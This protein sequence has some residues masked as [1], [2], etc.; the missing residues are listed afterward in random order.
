MPEYEQG[1]SYIYSVSE[2]KKGNMLIGVGGVYKKEKAKI[3]SID[4]NIDINNLWSSFDLPPI[5]TTDSTDPNIYGAASIAFDDENKL[6]VGTNVEGVLYFNNYLSYQIK[7]E[8]T[9]TFTLFPNPAS[10][11]V[12]ITISNSGL[13]NGSISI[14]NSS[15]VE[16]KRFDEKELSEQSSMCFSIEGFSTGMYYCA[17]K[18]GTKKVT[19]SFV[20]VK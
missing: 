11:F 3:L 20:I 7:N 16:I 1:K 9:E 19:K 15:G 8:V 10:D 18:A 4:K 2:D 5:G 17:M 6:W 14:F 13:L 12:S